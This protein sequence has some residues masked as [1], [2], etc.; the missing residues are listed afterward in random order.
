M[1]LLPQGLTGEDLEP[2]KGMLFR[3]GER[4]IRVIKCCPFVY[5]AAVQQ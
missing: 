1:L 3:D 4:W 5:S 2:S